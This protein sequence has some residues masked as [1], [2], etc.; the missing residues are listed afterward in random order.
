M[1]KSPDQRID[2]LEK[3]VR[4]YKLLSLSMLVLLLVT[5]RGRIVGWIDRMEG[6]V[7]NVASARS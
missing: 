2:S 5:Q 1:P 4:N 6:W 7:G 3:S